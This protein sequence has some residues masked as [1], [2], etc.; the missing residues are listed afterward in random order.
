MPSWKKL[1]VSGS[2][3]TLNSLQVTT[4]VTAAAFSGS[5]SGSFEGDGSGLTNLTV[6]IAE[7]ASFPQTFTNT[8]SV[9]VNHDLDT[10]YPLVQ[11][12]NEDDEQIIPLRIKILT[13]NSV[14]VDFSS[15]Q[16][17]YVIVAKGGHIISGTA[18]NSALLEGQPGSY[19]LD[20]NNFT[21][22]PPSGDSFPY[23]GSAIIT[24]SLDVIGP[25]TATTFV[26]VLSSSAQIASEI[27]GAFTSVSQSIASDIAGLVQDSG[28][29]STRISDLE[30]FS[31]SLDSDF[32][33]ET[34]FASASGSF[35]VTGSISGDTITLTKGD[36]S[37]FDL[38]VDNVNSASFTTTA[39]YVEWTGIQ[40]I[41][42][43]LVS[44]SDQ[45]TGSYD[46]RYVLSGSITQTTWD[47]IDNKPAGIVSSSVQIQ[48]DQISG[49]TFSASNFTFPQDLTVQGKI[50]AQEFY[51]ELISSSII[52]ESGSTKFG[53][54][55]DDVHSFTG[56]VQIFGSITGSLLATN[57][58][59]SSSAQIASDISGSFTSV[60]Q[61]IASD[62]SDLFQ[63]S[64]SFSTRISDLEQFSASLDLSFVSETEFA[65]AS[66][67]FLTTGSISGDTITLTK[68]DGS[69]FNLTVD[70]V[71][72]ATSASYVDWTDIDNIPAGIISSSAQIASDISGSFTAVSQ[73]IA[74]DIAGL[75]QDSGS[76][77][78]RISDL[79]QFSASLDSS[80]ISESEFALAS[81]SFLVTGSVS[82]DTITLTKGD[83]S[84]FNLTVD[85]V[86]S[87][88]FAFT[89][90]YV[91]WTDID[92]IP[93]GLLSS[94]AQIASD[95]SGSFTSVS[96]SIASDI[97]GLVQ[98]SGS[99]ST[100]I[101]DLEQFSSSADTIF[102][103]E[104]EFALASGS[105][106]V[107]AS[108][109]DDTLT[110]VKG[111]GTSFNLTVNNVQN[112]SSASYASFA[113]TA[114]LNQ[115]IGTI[116]SASNFTFLQD[117]T[118]QGKLTAQEFNTE[119]ISS[120]II[121]ESGSTKFGDSF[122]D[123]HQFTG[124]ILVTGSVSIND[125]TLPITDA[126]FPNSVLI[127]NGA[128][129]LEFDLPKT[130]YEEVK[131]VSGQFLVKG[132][133]V[134][135][136][137]ATGNTNN[138]APADA[139]DP[140]KMPA[141]FILDQPLNNDEEGLGIILGF[142]NQIDTSGLI[143]GKTVY[144]APGGGY[145][146]TRPTGSALVQ[147]L[148]IPVNIDATNGSGVIFNPGTSLDLPNIE[149]G[150]FWFGDSNSVPTSASVESLRSGSF[151]GS[152]QGNGSG[153]TGLVSASHAVNA[154]TASLANFATTAGTAN[155]A[156]YVDW[157]NVDNIPDFLL[158]SEFNTYTGSVDTFSGSFSTR[159]TSLENFSASLDSDFVSESEFALASGSFLTTGSVAGDTI[160]L[161]KGDG[162]TFNLIV[163][164]VNSA[165]FATT[166]SYVDWTD[167]DN[168]PVGIISSSAQL[169]N[170][171]LTGMTVS[172]SFSGSFQ[173]D[174]SG[175]TGV[176]VNIETE[177]LVSSTFTSTGS[178]TVNHSLDTLFPL[179]QV[180]NEEDEQVIPLRIKILSSSSIQIDFSTP[181]SGYVVIAK[182]G[183][184]VSGS[185]LLVDLTD[186]TTFASTFTSVT[187]S[188][189]VHNLN[190]AYPLVQVY[191]TLDEQVIP[192]T[193]KILNSSSVEVDFS[194]PQSGYIVVAKAG[195][196][197]SGSSANSALLENQPG[198]Y[199]LD[200]SNFTN[201]PAGIVSS[202]AQITE[203]TYY[204]EQISGSLSYTVDHYLN[205]LFP[206][207]QVYNSSYEQIIP[208]KVKSNSNN[209]ILVE[210][211]TIFDGWVVV[212]V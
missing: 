164:N 205:E 73:S 23:T 111:D 59:L 140:S 99:F 109:S 77:S 179:V 202:S 199:Y 101:T 158:E 173:G 25:L 151:S 72:N 150:Y 57:G 14:Q 170:T 190:T 160:T 40:N 197:V 90:S 88:S 94:S 117:L 55:L 61:S 100:R 194:T 65:L 62:I 86:N 180:Y 12:Y 3:A 134:Y 10:S 138:V 181:Q 105:F 172:G 163:D 142:I 193:I 31:A 19:Y 78:T 18:S 155:T 129:V 189:V 182:G 207:V 209:Q 147:A 188:T 166:A 211:S 183:H 81:G 51:T 22:I 196:I 112:A 120:S 141:S 103:S 16:S 28:S 26:G 115:L 92:N 8:S 84:T 113:E 106:L 185:V 97:A 93:A 36:G 178:I 49:T 116:F 126:E 80:F 42:S 64:G 114:P 34:E 146:Q 139:S 35:L 37:T 91:D 162:S 110:L 11:V 108:I 33:S 60:S 63:D 127:S 171:T 131:N 157:A 169:D 204:K 82:A 107:T 85:N 70:N 165:S 148:G 24:G 177:T 98:D 50:T 186:Q 44:G 27:S 132:T 45:L 20:Y 47:N 6:E 212:K 5:F 68:G 1:L 143:A 136:V 161:T 104:S 83:G 184:I 38:T 154:D 145:T 203:L 191:N 56:S 195:H 74:S 53:D 87:A 67:S 174:G 168:I 75:V 89:A 95:I 96:Q 4:N 76:F 7:I 119:L 206:V 152:F 52:Y 125:Y 135:V 69:T 153:L 200:Y 30:N 54:S 46:Q 133:P 79:E 121:Y 176:S 43:G 137:S 21:N 175:L 192:Q 9:V 167:I 123:T 130:I 128:G 29:F 17:G 48:L 122:D 198:S 118:V 2:D 13:A 124:S 144:V 66:G 32:V 210:F 15:N 159:I 201:V 208:S 156:S 187:S 41:P 102:V 71:E 39:S 149:P 58:I